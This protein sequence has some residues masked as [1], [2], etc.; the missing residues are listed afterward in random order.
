MLVSG[1]TEKLKQSSGAR[2]PLNGGQD[3]LIEL[4]DKAVKRA[5]SVA[6][7]VGR[8]KLDVTT[9]SKLRRRVT[10]GLTVRSFKRLAAALGMT[11]ERLVRVICRGNGT[12][13]GQAPPSR[14]LEQAQGRNESGSSTGAE[15]LKKQLESVVNGMVPSFDGPI[16]RFHFPNGDLVEIERA[17]NQR[18][19][20]V[21]EH[22]G[23]RVTVGAD[24]AGRCS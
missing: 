21:F 17:D 4:V 15:E 11:S 19:P 24:P 13:G 16:S 22:A 10:R 7:F 6:A 20:L 5:G 2:I 8:S 9:V 18:E 3:R 1:M 12:T 23:V 14:G